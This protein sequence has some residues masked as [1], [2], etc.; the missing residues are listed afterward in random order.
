MRPHYIMQPHPRANRA[1][2]VPQSTLLSPI[3]RLNPLLSSIRCPNRPARLINQQFV[4]FDKLRTSSEP[5]EGTSLSSIRRSPPHPPLDWS[6]RDGRPR[7]SRGRRQRG[8]RC[9]GRWR[10]NAWSRGERCQRAGWPCAG[11][12]S[13][14]RPRLRG[15]R[16]RQ[17]KCYP[18]IHGQVAVQ[19]GVNTITASPDK[20]TPLLLCLVGYIY[21][22]EVEP[23]TK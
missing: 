15:C 2:F 3:P 8:W 19:C 6:S 7:Y 9:A 23:Y 22:S 14:W 18:P 1:G 10:S 21:L 4:P 11:A 13:R 20:R 5:A 17:Q 16:S 12:G